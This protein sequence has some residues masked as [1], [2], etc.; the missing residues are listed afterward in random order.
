M[1]Q[2]DKVMKAINS[3]EKEAF[4]RKEIVDLSGASSVLV[5]N[6]CNKLVE[7]GVLETSKEGR[8]VIYRMTENG[9]V[10]RSVT[11]IPVNDRFRYIEKFTEMVVKGI[12]PSFLLT[13]QAGIGKTY[14]VTDVLKRNGLVENEDYVIIK[15]HSSPMGL[16]GALYHNQE[17]IVV[18]D[19]MDSCWQNQSMINILKAAL[20]SYG[21]RIVSWNSIGAERNDMEQSF[22]FKGAIIFISNI[23]SSK[24]DKAVVNRT[25]TAN[26]AMSNGEILE[27]I[28]ELIPNLNPEIEMTKKY[29]VI[30][31][32]KEQVNHFKNLSIR[33]FLQAS[34]IREGS[35]SDWQ[36][37]IL[38][39]L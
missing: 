24:L 13:G 31:F 3:I 21:K 14:S 5:G 32:M 4:S 37:M 12:S 36:N 28:E 15:G 35:N 39:T 1:K 27:R 17:K 2:S 8:N 18:L 22:E 30:E 38:Y 34:K 26:L 7:D 20:D 6:I 19:D 33:T 10:D 11:Q 23:D 16:Y 29:E 25:I 9:V